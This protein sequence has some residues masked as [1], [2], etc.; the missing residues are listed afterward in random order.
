[1]TD[2]LHI[3]YIKFLESKGIIGYYRILFNGL[4]IILIIM[5]IYCL[6]C[7]EEL[8]TG[9][10]SSPNFWEISD[11]LDTYLQG[12]KI[13]TEQFLPIEEVLR[14]SLAGK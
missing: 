9:V 5:I 1:M 7:E 13:K 14:S 6:I 12:D 3:K 11:R 2:T 8:L 10:K 4:I